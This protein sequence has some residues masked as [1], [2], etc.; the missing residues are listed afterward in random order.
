M[1]SIRLNRQEWNYDS[2]EPLG[3][4]GGFGNVY[5]GLSEDGRV[6]AVKKLK[7]S[8]KEL[9]HRELRIAEKLYSSKFNNVLA[10]L[11]SGLDAES[12]HYFIVMEKAECSL[13][14]HIEKAGALPEDEAVSILIQICN[15]LTEVG[16]IVH[17]DLKPE[18]ILLH[19][20]LW[21]V[22]DF[23]IARF[24]EES[25]SL[26]TLK[27][28]LTPAYAAPEQWRFERST[29]KTDIYAIGCIAHA[30]ATGVPPFSGPDNESY[31]D[32]HISE[33]PNAIASFGSIT[34]SLISTMLR[35]GQGVRP[36]LPRC[37]SVFEQILSSI[38]EKSRSRSA[39]SRASEEVARK[40]L[41]ED[42]KRQKEAEKAAERHALQDESFVILEGI[43][44]SL[45]KN[46]LQDAPAARQSSPQ[47]DI[48]LGSGVLRIHFHK[49]DRHKEGEFPHSRWDVL[50][51]ATITV[52]Q[53]SRSSY[54]WGCNLLFTNR[55]QGDFRWYEVGFMT[56]ALQ[57]RRAEP[58]A[59][60]TDEFGNVDYAL[61][62]I[63]HNWQP[64][65]GPVAIDME[66]ES[67]FI[68][69]WI[70]LFSKAA[71]GTLS[72]PRTLPVSEQYFLQGIG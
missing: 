43:M 39:L 7:M 6:V 34:N 48:F 67:E 38:E 1:I 32:Q 51:S 40:Q 47:S 53:S 31:R 57:K 35:K 13:A 54:T 50:S 25:T 59:A 9:A 17:R 37:I 56:W 30:L 70:L 14:D 4:G 10:V 36:S 45:C 49:Y 66:G 19:E 8:A 27:D 52:E 3:R 28:C 58:F 60:R 64:A 42:A 29:G 16:D 20:G 33:A 22:A 24:V 62:N 55:G 18:N 11:D 41:E 21:K 46:I 68:D 26:R 12:D 23:G 72:R 69:R 44:D 61:S 2:D 63:T 71:A 65:W 15:G 5:E